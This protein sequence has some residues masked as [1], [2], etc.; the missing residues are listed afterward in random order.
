TVRDLLPPSVRRP[1]FGLLGSLYP[2]TEF[3]PQIFRGKAFLSNVAR[4]PWEAYLHSVSAIAEAD[5]QRLLS[6]DVRDALGGYRTA[7]LFEDLYRRAD[8]PGPLCR[9][10][11][12]HFSTSPPQDNLAQ[13]H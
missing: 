7:D 9:P 6:G 8:G 11:D 4:T 13:L 1:L 5:K 3:L 10:P 2:Q 12:I